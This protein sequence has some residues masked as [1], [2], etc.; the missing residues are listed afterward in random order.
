MKFT[1]PNTQQGFT[2]I[3]LMIV[4]AIIGILASIAVP[5]YQ[6]YVK[7]AKFSEV[8][9]ATSTAKTGV[10]LCF[11]TLAA[12]TECDD[13]KNGINTVGASG[14]LLSIS[15]TDGVITATAASTNG[16]N[17]ET[18]IMTPTINTGKVTWINSGTC[19][20]AGLC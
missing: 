6:T 19:V 13:S 9:M 4:V 16:L 14:Y 17:G 20:T 12:L 15:T 8:V 5:S 7:K 10:E 18:Y 2:L 3:E 1:S 11:Q